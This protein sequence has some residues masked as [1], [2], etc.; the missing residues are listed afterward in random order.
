LKV[1]IKRSI[2]YHVYTTGLWGSANT[3]ATVFPYLFSTFYF[4]SHIECSFILTLFIIHLFI[5]YWGLDLGPH[6]Y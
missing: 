2:S 6:F 4:Y 1:E 3:A 5:W